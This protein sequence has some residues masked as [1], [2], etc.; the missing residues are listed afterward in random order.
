MSLWNVLGTWFC[1][2]PNKTNC[3]GLY[4][5]FPY[6]F[7]LS[8]IGPSYVYCFQLFGFYLWSHS[9][10][11]RLTL[12]PWLGK[13]TT[14]PPCSLILPPWSILNLVCLCQC[15]YHLLCVSLRCVK[16]LNFETCHC[17]PLPT[18]P[19]ERESV[20]YIPHLPLLDWKHALIWYNF[21]SLIRNSQVP[22]CM[23]R[24][25]IDCN[26]KR[27]GPRVQMQFSGRWE[28]WLNSWI[29]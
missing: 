10:Q 22:S 19:S 24:V 26:E 3:S 1:L 27:P 6:F 2:L 23:G 11:L 16:T 28:N 17:S 8:L 9:T 12:F 20:I 25:W 18:S 4:C 14:A 29:N 5:S 7:Y 13:H 21:K 15:E